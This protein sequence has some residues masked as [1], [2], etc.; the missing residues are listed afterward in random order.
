LLTTLDSPVCQSQVLKSLP[1]DSNGAY[2]DTVQESSND[3]IEQTSDIPRPAHAIRSSPSPRKKIEETE[4]ELDEDI[5]AVKRIVQQLVVMGIETIGLVLSRFDLLDWIFDLQSN[6][7]LRWS[8]GKPDW[9]LGTSS[10]A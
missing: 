3:D 1:S 4:P 6:I 8:K 2:E 5:S 7:W 9:T 10:K